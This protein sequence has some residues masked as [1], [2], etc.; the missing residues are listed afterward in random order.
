[1]PEARAVIERVAQER[2]CRLR[3][4]GVDFRYAYRP[5]QVT[6]RG[7]QKSCV[8]VVTERRTWPEL[9]LNLLGEHQAANAA[10]AI[11][12]IEELT[13]QGWHISERAVREGLAEVQWPARMEVVSARP[14]VVLDCAH[15]VASALAL[16]ETLLTSFPPSRRWLI[17]AGSND[18]DLAGMFRA[19]APHFHH[20]FLTRYTTNP[21]ATPPEQL[22]ELLASAGPLPFSIHDIAE[23]A[24]AVARQMVGAEDLLCISGSVFLAGELRPML[25][26]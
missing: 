25:T 4:L 8:R 3:Q 5:G 14:W 11:A 24:L 10:V 16:V 12:C 20:A 22:A 13:R 1:V 21:R 26:G 15:N 7:T 18:K 6:A 2:G 23:A 9:E 17:F 19:L